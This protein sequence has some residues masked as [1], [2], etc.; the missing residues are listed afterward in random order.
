MKNNVKDAL[1]WL[2]T[3]THVDSVDAPDVVDEVLMRSNSL[4]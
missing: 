4:S 1:R 3:S 2:P